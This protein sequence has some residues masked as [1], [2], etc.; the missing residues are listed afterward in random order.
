M[1]ASSGFNIVRDNI[2]YAVFAV[3]SN[4]VAQLPDAAIQLLPL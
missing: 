2:A 4:G 3:R 1:E